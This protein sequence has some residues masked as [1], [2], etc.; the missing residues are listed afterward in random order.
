MM[1]GTLIRFPLIFASGIFI[2]LEDLPSWA[3]GI[4]YASPV[5][6][7]NNLMHES[8]RGDSFLA[9]PICVAA[10]VTFWMVFLLVGAKLQALGKRL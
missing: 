10:L 2:P 8:V 9:I 3:R 1:L 4:A 5:T 6:Y 7:S